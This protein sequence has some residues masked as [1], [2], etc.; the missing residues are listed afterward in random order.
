MCCLWLLFMGY[1][2]NF[3]Y[4]LSC[5]SKQF[6]F[7]D[8]TTTNLHHHCFHYFTKH[9]KLDTVLNTFKTLLT[10]YLIYTIILQYRSYI[11][12]FR[13]GNESQRIW[14]NCSKS[15]KWPKAEWNFYSRI[16]EFQNSCSKLHYYFTLSYTLLYTEELKW[17]SDNLLLFTCKEFFLSSH[18]II[19]K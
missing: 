4:S 5:A 3:S 13:W 15:H 8:V 2:A 16:V 6:E 19:S 11:T 1:L 12:Y 7:L 9:N 14:V 17:V 10:Y 18:R